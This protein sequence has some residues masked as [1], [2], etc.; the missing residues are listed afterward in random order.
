MARAHRFQM[1]LTLSNI[2]KYINSPRY[3]SS[4]PITPSKFAQKYIFLMVCIKYSYEY[5]PLFWP[6]LPQSVLTFYGIVLYH[7]CK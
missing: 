1:K 3:T 4:D 6:V 2:S 7:S 5:Q